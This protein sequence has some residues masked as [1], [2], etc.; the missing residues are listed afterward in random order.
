VLFVVPAVRQGHNII[1]AN[2]YLGYQIGQISMPLKVKILA[3]H[4]ITGHFSAH[5]SPS[6]TQ[7]SAP[8]GLGQGTRH[9]LAARKT[10]KSRILPVSLTMVP[11]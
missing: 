2:T 9:R 8:G 1:S 6:A 5:S 11:L 4:P 7:R 10:V 3:E